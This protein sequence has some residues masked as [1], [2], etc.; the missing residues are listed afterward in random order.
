M[1]GYWHRPEATEE[2]SSTAGTARATL[3]TPTRLAPSSWSTGSRP[4]VGTAGQEA[5]LCRRAARRARHPHPTC[6][7][8]APDRRS[9]STHWPRALAGLEALER[10]AAAPLWALRNAL[11]RS[12]LKRRSSARPR[13]PRARCPRRAPGCRGGAASPREAAPAPPRGARPATSRTRSRRPRARR[14]GDG[15][16]A[17]MDAR[18]AGVGE[19]HGVVRC[20]ADRHVVDQ[21]KPAVVR[22]DDLEHAAR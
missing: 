6:A 3:R 11:P 18:H 16:D 5:A 12:H 20:P 1:L 8:G 19:S 2:A 17:R 13:R 7:R 22:E 9:L 10:V 14:A 21:R 15:R 4:L